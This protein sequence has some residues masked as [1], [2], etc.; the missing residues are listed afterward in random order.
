MTAP[1]GASE[2]ADDRE[3]AARP[4]GAV[5]GLIAP[6]GRRRGGRDLA[7]GLA[8]RRSA[9]R[10]RAGRP[11]RAAASARRRPR[12]SP[13]SARPGRLDVGEH[14][15]ARRRAGRGRPAR[16]RRPARPAM[17]ARWMIALVE[18]PTR[19]AP[20]SRCR[21]RPRSACRCGRRSRQDRLDRDPAGRGARPPRPRSRPRPGSTPRPAPSARAPRHSTAIVEAV[22]IVLHAPSPQLSAS[23][24]SRHPSSSSRP[25]RRSSHIRH[26]P[27]PVPIGR[28]RNTRTGGTPPVTRT[29]GTLALIAPISAPGTLLSQ[30]ARMTSPSSG[31]A[32]TIS[33]TSIASRLRYSI[34][35][36]FIRSSPSEIV[37]ELRRRSR[38]PRHAAPTAPASSRS[39]RLHG[40]SSLAEF[41][42]PITGRPAPWPTGRPAVASATRCC[43]ATSS[44]PANH[45]WLRPDRA[46]ERRARTRRP[47]PVVS[48]GSG[49]PR[50]G[51]PGWTGQLQPA[52]AHPLQR[53]LGP[54]D[55]L[56][57]DRGRVVRPGAGR[58]GRAAASCAART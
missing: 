30:L 18:P 3:R 7:D 22:P 52:A 55:L 23:S 40:F 51:A 42:I 58:S 56:P 48:H 4:S 57:G 5:A 11:A 13:A 9:R 35:L 38:P 21:T 47:A 27:V 25:A 1:S 8:G 34:A 54:V 46:A 19:A 2:P 28:P 29:V 41:A 43:S 17:A 44:S 15:H 37:A 6:R 26:R 39:G 50:P 33:S 12:R 31:L 49:T 14:R 53:D 20:G 24:S 10:C 45:V 36:G 32:R 16:T